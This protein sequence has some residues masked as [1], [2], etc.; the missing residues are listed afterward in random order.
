MEA[1]CAGQR[2]S[3]DCFLDRTILFR[4]VHCSTSLVFLHLLAW[5]V[6]QYQPTSGTNERACVREKKLI[7]K[8]T[9]FAI[10]FF[11][12]FNFVEF[13]RWKAKLEKAALMLG[14]VGNICLAF[15]FFPVT[16]G[17]SILQL[18]GLTSE[19]SIKYHIWL[20][21]IAMTLFTAHG[22]SYI[23]FWTTTNQI[24]EVK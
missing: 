18:L 20:G 13:I 6:C 4:H 7:K 16:R 2:P 15:L 19:S 23:I 21:H 14:L 17:S 1:T 24:S 11:F 22:V 10:S 5:Y 8:S 3:R 9:I 12:L